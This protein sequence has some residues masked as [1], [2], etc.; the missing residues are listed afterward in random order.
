MHV[1]QLCKVLHTC[2]VC[3]PVES[4]SV[5]L[6][7]PSLFLYHAE[8]VLWALAV[9]WSALLR[10]C[11]L[12]KL[13]AEEISGHKESTDQSPNPGLCSHMQNQAHLSLQSIRM[14]VTFLQ[15]GWVHLLTSAPFLLPGL[16]FWW[17]GRQK[18]VASRPPPSHPT[19]LE[20]SPDWWPCQCPASCVGG[21]RSSITLMS[22]LMLTSLV[23]PLWT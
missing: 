19:N 13:G 4:L 18:A 14:Y 20:D 23:L 5:A 3:L 17:L 16:K 15:A 9:L 8:Q 11:T 10:G 12:V 1:K 7:M 21:F 22:G 2:A 6:R